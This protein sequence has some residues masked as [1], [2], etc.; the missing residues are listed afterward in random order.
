MNSTA[1]SLPSSGKLPEA[2]AAPSLLTGLANLEQPYTWNRY[3]NA[4]AR[5]AHRMP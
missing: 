3:E 1:A 5:P 4:A 2:G